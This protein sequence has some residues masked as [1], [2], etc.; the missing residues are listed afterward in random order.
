MNEAASFSK[1][2]NIGANEPTREILD[3]ALCEKPSCNGFSDIV[4][5]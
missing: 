1:A 4:C 2:E 5:R 3:G